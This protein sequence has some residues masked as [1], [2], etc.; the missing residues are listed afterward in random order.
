MRV[1]GLPG[2]PCRFSKLG[3]AKLTK[4]ARESLC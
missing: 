2:G 1:I 4:D 3:Y